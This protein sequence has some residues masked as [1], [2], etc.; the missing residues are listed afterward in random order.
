M[1]S[2]I[3]GCQCFYERSQEYEFSSDPLVGFENVAKLLASS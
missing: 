1:V 2:S 3:V